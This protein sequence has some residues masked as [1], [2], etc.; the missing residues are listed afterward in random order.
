MNIS[1][2]IAKRASDIETRIR[3]FLPEQYEYQKLYQ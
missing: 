2:E 3:R 1:D